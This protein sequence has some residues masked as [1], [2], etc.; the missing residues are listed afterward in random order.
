MLTFAA[1]L[2]GIHTKQPLWRI[3]P[4][5]DACAPLRIAKPFA[6]PVQRITALCFVNRLQLRDARH[7][8][9]RVRGNWGFIL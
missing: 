1:E 3:G 7:R 6:I 4:L 9:N 5:P 2:A 8:A